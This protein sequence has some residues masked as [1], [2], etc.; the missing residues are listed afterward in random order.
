[1]DDVPIVSERYVSIREDIEKTK[2]SRL[3]FTLL[4]SQIRNNIF[5]PKYYDPE[6]NDQLQRLAA[7]HDPVLIGDL[8]KSSILAFDTGI[9][10]G[11]MAYGTGHF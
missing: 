8:V 7:T 4:H 10:V 9:E 3:G 11:K 6:I 2:P 5:V 1:M